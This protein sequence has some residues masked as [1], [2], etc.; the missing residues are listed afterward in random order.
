MSESAATLLP[1]EDFNHLS[2]D[3][4]KIIQRCRK[5]GQNKRNKYFRRWIDYVR[6][7]QDSLKLNDQLNCSDLES[8]P[9][10]GTDLSS[11]PEVIQAQE[12]PIQAL[13]SN[14]GID[15]LNDKNDNENGMRQMIF[16]I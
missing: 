10:L 16:H 2:P 14:P 4:K 13:N 7:A 8:V 12:L 6:G 9:S 5:K 1:K 3:L 11:V 15:A